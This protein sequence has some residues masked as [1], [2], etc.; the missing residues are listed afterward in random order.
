MPCFEYWFLL[1]FINHTALLKNYPKVTN[2][3][4]PYMKGCFPA[5]FSSV[6]FKK[7]MKSEKY[8]T[9][10]V[11]VENLCSGGKLDDAVSRAESNLQAAIANGELEQQ[12]YTKV[13]KMFRG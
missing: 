10:A 5:A 3:L 7:L 9:D 8:L 2:L 13:Y 11:W 12:S 6:K 4:S 1:H